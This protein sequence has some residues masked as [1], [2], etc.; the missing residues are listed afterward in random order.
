MGCGSTKIDRQARRFKDD[1]MEEI[2]F[3]GHDNRQR[4]RG[5]NSGYYGDHN[6]QPMHQGQGQGRGRGHGQ[7]HRRGQGNGRQ[8]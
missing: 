6:D 4:Y 5:G 3:G 2:G 7:G 8:H 1:V